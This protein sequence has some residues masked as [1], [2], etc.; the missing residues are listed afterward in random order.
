MPQ[1]AA[2]FGRQ[3]RL[4]NGAQYR[5]VFSQRQSVHGKYFSVHV[6]GNSLGHARLGLTVSRKVSKRAVQRNRIKRQVRESFRL[7]RGEMESIDFVTV[8]KPGCADQN[9]DVL[10]NELDRLWPR[11]DEKCKKY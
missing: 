3:Y 8:A 7:N 10:R 5:Q 9:N 2:S 11:A 6:A 1:V 4:L